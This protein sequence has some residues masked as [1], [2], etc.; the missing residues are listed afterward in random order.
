MFWL[1]THTRL[2]HRLSAFIDGQLSEKERQELAT[3]LEACPAC[4]QE[5]E[6]LRATVLALGGLPQEE[7][8]RSFALRPE[9]AARRVLPSP[10]GGLALT[11][12]LAGASL[13]AALAVL[14]VVDLADLGGNGPLPAPAAVPAPETLEE[15]P[16]PAAPPP[17]APDEFRAEAPYGALEEAPARVT[18]T[19]SPVPPELASER[20]ELPEGVSERMAPQGEAEGGI[21]PLRA[22]EIALAAALGAMIL[23]AAALGLRIRRW[24]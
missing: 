16:P 3:H 6:E 18:P 7:A 13:A 22:A 2:R 10:V 24:P 9:Q 15:A 14:L 19:P 5:L 23:A 17:V 21:D 8:P 20:A 11:M 12:R 4:R 1:R